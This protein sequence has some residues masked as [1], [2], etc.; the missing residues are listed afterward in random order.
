MFVQ[1][2][3]YIGQPIEAVTAALAMGPRK[4]FP[5]LAL[6]GRAAVGPE[7]AGIGLRKEVFVEVGDPVAIGSTTQVPVTWQA[8]FVKNL[9]PLMTG[10]VEIAPVDPRTTKLT[11]CGMYEPPLGSLGRH[12]DDALMY[13]VAAATVK[14]LA[15]SVAKRLAKG[16]AA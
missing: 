5:R 9:F 6:P 13:K 16:A 2:S 12:L 7:I 1:H 10:K 15:E 11:V 8:T 14:D 3:V 4:W